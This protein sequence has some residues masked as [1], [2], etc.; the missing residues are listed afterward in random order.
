MFRLTI[1]IIS[2]LF[3]Q[4]ANKWTPGRSINLHA[5]Y[6]NIDHLHNIYLIQQNKILKYNQS[7][8]KLSEYSMNY[9][10]NITSIDVSDPMILP[11]MLISCP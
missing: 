2:F 1:L 4:N 7:G 5:E 11:G 3:F 8:E 10:G 6:I 9:S